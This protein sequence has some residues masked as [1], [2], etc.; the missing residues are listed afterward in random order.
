MSHNLYKGNV[1][2]THLIIQN[3]MSPKKRGRQFLRASPHHSLF[4][5]IFISLLSINPKECENAFLNPC[6]YAPAIVK[7]NL[8]C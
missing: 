1:D 2:I 3:L 6:A 7:N 4:P 8:K 5:P